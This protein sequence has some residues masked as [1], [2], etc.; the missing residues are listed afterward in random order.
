MKILDCLEDAALLV[1]ELKTMKSV[2]FDY[3]IDEQSRLSHYVLLRNKW[4]KKF[5]YFNYWCNTKYNM[6]MPLVVELI[7]KALTSYFFMVFFYL[8]LISHIFNMTN[9]ESMCW[10]SVKKYRFSLVTCI[11]ILCAL[12]LR[13]F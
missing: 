8:N 2:F 4:S 12:N 9:C 3:K 13:R 6:N 5:V 10:L 11:A 1:R 7:T